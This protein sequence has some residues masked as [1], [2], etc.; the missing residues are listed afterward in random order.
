[1][2]H[3]TTMRQTLLHI[4]SKCSTPLSGIAAKTRTDRLREL[5]ALMNAFSWDIVKMEKKNTT[6]YAKIPLGD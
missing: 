4:H 1:M 6:M 3:S 5:N 2:S